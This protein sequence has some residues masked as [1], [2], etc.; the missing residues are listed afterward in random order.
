MLEASGQ[1]T[2]L[3][4]AFTGVLVWGEVRWK[5]EVNHLEASFTWNE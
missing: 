2:G 1:E 4:K 3:G 5:P